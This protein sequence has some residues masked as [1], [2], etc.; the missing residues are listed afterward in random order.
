MTRQRESRDWLRWL[1]AGWLIAG[2]CDITYAI[3]YSFLRRGVAPSRVLQ[4]VASGALGRSAYDGRLATAALGLGFHFLFAF[5]F[6]C[7]FFVAASRV[8][9]LTRRPILTGVVYGIGIF[10]VMNNIVIPLSRIGP[11]PVPPMIALA[12]E[13]LVHMFLIGLPIALAARRAFGGARSSALVGAPA[14]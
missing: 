4:S 2:T 14:Y 6:T 12:P 9:V 5:I 8:A 10:A 13:V 1:I 11:R 3:T 7:A